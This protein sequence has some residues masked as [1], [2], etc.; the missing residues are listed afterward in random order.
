MHPLP[1]DAIKR[2]AATVEH[3]FVVEELEPYLEEQI[4]A[5][6]LAVEGKQWFSPLGELTPERV[7][8]GFFAAGLQLPRWAEQKAAEDDSVIPRPPVLCTGC[9]HQIGRAHV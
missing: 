7:G 6:G 8:R 2:F 3:L 9:P 5:A 4:I 1:V